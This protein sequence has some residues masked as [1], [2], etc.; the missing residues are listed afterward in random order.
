[1]T[2]PRVVIV[3]AGHAGGR[4]AET[5]MGEGFQGHVTLVGAE[6]HPPY[7]R[8]PLSKQLL[9]GCAT[10]DSTYL[11]PAS[12]WGEAGVSLVLGRHVRSVDRATKT[13]FL[14]SGEA[15]SYDTLVIATG[16]RSRRWEGPD[17][18]RDRL[19]YLRDI[20]DATRLAL[21]LR[22]GAHIAVI[23]AG[24]VGLEVAAAARSLGAE[25]TVVEVGG[26]AMPR[27]VLPEFS[28]VLTRC[29]EK[30]GVRFRFGTR[31]VSIEDDVIRLSTGEILRANT[32]VVGIGSIP[33]TDLAAD[34][35]LAVDDGILVD[36]YGR[37]NDP[38]IYAIGDVAR[39][40]N[41]LLGRRVRLESWQNAQDGAVAIARIIAGQN[42]PYAEMPWFWSE[43]YDHN[44][45]CAGLPLQVDRIVWRG[46]PG[47]GS[48]MAFQMSGNTV[49]GVQALNGGR[50]M[51]FGRQLLQGG[52]SIDPERLSDPYSNLQEIARVA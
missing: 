42:A 36:A 46:D 11:R 28:A 31:V 23:G 15:L 35:G 44:L 43:Q 13:I 3:G 50:D 38:C 33:N 10:P 9:I 5:L 41:D 40:V 37:T 49:V 39:H 8:P 45:Q 14:D 21:E 20:G 1:M 2:K 29:H 48:A 12:W 17:I 16:A 47:R 32:I 26:R 4:V 25:V 6:A 7:E 52:R 18:N 51:R 22:A 19:F 24:F 34:A 30:Q 27:I